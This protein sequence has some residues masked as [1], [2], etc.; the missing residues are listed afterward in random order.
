WSLFTT[1][2]PGLLGSAEHFRARFAGPIE[3]NADETARKA[4]AEVIRPFILRRLKSEVASD[5]PPR[6]DVRIDIE[7]SEPERRLY[8]RLRL[9]TIE[10]LNLP[11]PEDRA[12]KSRMRVLAAMLRLRQ[13]ACHPRL[14]DPESEVASSKHHVLMDLVERAVE[15]GHQILVFSQFTS[16]L[17]LVATEL[18]RAGIRFHRLQ[19]NTPTRARRT[20]VDAF[21]RGEFDVFLLS[22]KAA[23][24]GLNLTAAE[25]VVHLDPW[26]NP[27]IEDQATDRAHRIGQDKPVTVY[28][29]VST[30]TIEETIMELHG[31]K[32]ALMNDLLAGTGKAT[33]LSPEQLMDLI[34]RGV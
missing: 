3:R 28:R 17:D 26:W 27:A 7:L 34:S 2:A 30:D 20:R 10:A 15:G 29:L 6:T 19:G 21:Q 16:H 25:Y 12:D 18:E 31:E 24:T 9:S 13:L 32:R 11:G 22:L 5:L 14:V 4:L 1:V 33:T 8:D 23:G